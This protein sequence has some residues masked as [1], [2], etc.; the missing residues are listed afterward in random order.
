MVFLDPNGDVPSVLLLA[1]QYGKQWFSVYKLLK[2]NILGG[3]ERHH[4][5]LLAN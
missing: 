4:A 3:H 1:V 2:L 5:L